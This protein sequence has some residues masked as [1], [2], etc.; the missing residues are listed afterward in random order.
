MVAADGRTLSARAAIT[1]L[2]LGVLAS[3]AVEFVPPL[4]ESKRRALSELVM[5]PV[6]K[7][8]LHFSEPF[9]P[10]WLAHLGC[11][12][13]PVTVYW[14][15]FR[16]RRA[17]DRRCSPPTARARAPRISPG[18]PE[19][20]AVAIVL[21]DLA[22]LF[23][24][25]DPGRLLLGY[26]RIDWTTD[27]FARGGYTFTRPGGR[28]ARGASG[29]GRHRGVVLGRRRH[30]HLDNRGDGAGRLR[31]RPA[32]GVGGA[33]LPGRRAAAGSR[34]QKTRA[35]EPMIRCSLEVTTVPGSRLLRRMSS[36]SNRRAEAGR[37][38]AARAALPD[39]NSLRVV[40]R[41]VVLDLFLVVVGRVE[42]PELLPA[43]VE[44]EADVAELGFER[45]EGEEPLREVVS[46]ELEL[47]LDSDVGEL[48]RPPAAQASE[49]TWANP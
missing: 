49:V 14:P 41:E 27:P 13:G 10:A 2:P 46:V 42:G 12:T 24:K 5:G 19:D 43:A 39:R 16:G 32:C 6:L 30:G 31:E 47:A 18:A 15:R 1:T 34:G 7:V 26:R 3:G 4:P 40:Q 33:G 36:S 48:R 37:R 44:S 8:L 22:R 38:R 11:G 17:N 25:A 23:P 9:W 20:E 21:A 45:R 28:G 35:A 29:G